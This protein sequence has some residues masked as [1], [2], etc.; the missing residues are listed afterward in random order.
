M[1]YSETNSEELFDRFEENEMP[2]EKDP[3]CNQT[4]NR[5]FRESYSHVIPAFF[6]RTEKCRKKPSQ[7]ERKRLRYFYNITGTLLMAKLF[8]EAASL[9]VFYILMFLFAFALSPNLNFYY[10]A[11]S[12]ETIK[13]AFRIIAVI[14][15]SGSVFFAGCRFSELKPARLLK[16][17]G[18]IKTGDVVLSF[19]TGMFVA[20]LANIITFSFPFSPTAYMP[21]AMYIEKDWTLVAAA[22]LC[23]CIVIPAADGL[24]FRGLALKNLSRASQRFGIITSS[25]L[26]ALATCSLPAMLPAF[27][28]S[29]LLCS[30]TVKYNSV[31]P[32]V[33]IHMAVNTSS[34]IISVYSIFAWDQSELL[35]RVWTI[36]TLVLGGV[37]TFIRL[38]RE[39]LPKN[40]PEQ[41][42]RALPVLLTSAFV[43][44]LF[45]LYALTSLAKLLYFMYM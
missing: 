12:D 3:F 10:S 13:Y 31:I 19:M 27:L 20:A 37:F 18:T 8:I 4:E 41:R 24:I 5:S 29:L 42:R 15:S 16:G 9:L 14:V 26:C 44:L 39:P 25:L 28:M 23:N 40:K 36:I 35:M 30:I 34:M 21:S 1:N 32:S 7:Y 38:I 17:K 2:D 33:L 11:L 22:A 45:P 43:I 6:F